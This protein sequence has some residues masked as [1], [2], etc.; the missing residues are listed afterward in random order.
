MYS[1]RNDDHF[2][3]LRYERLVVSYTLDD[4]RQSTLNLKRDLP[5]TERGKTPNLE[6]VRVDIHTPPASSQRGY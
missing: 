6:T 3:E 1:A 2:A 5:R 4:L